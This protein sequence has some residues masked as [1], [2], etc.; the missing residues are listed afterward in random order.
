MP[1]V[2]EPRQVER[3]KLRDEGL[4][5]TPIHRRESHRFGLNFR[6]VLGNPVV[7]C[8]LAEERIDPHPCNHR[9]RRPPPE[10]RSPRSDPTPPLGTYLLLNLVPSPPQFSLVHRPARYG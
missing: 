5:S 2:G 6:E 8:S 10:R 7:G 1:W 9:T 3:P 4:V